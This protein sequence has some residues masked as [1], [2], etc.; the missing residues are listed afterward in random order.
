[1][2]I[3]TEHTETDANYDAVQVL[4]ALSCIAATPAEVSAVARTLLRLAPQARHDV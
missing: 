1:M 3:K 4:L 2:D